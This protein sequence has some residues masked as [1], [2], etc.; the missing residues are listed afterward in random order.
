MAVAAAEENKELLK[1]LYNKLPP[2]GACI[3]SGWIID[4]SHL[5]PQ[6]SVLFCLEDICWNAPDVERSERV[7]T[8]W[9][10]TAGFKEIECKTYLEP[11]KMLYGIKV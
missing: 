5:A 10:K 6:I 1:K 2:Q 7:Y 9:L 4:D 11:T 3:L 8:E